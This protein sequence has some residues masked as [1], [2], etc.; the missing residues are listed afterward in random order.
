MPQSLKPTKPGHL[1]VVRRSLG[2]LGADKLR[3]TILTGA[4]EPGERLTEEGIA[5]KLGLSRSTIRAC[6]IRLVHEG[7][8]VQEPYLGYSVRSLSSRDAWELFTLRNSMESFAAKILSES[9]S[10]KKKKRLDSAYQN[11]LTA[12][13]NGSRSAAVQADFSLHETIAELTE[14]KAFQYH[15]QLI[16][17]QVKLYQNLVSKFLSLEDYVAT[18]Q[19]L[20]D[21]IRA[22]DS[23]EAQLLAA[24]HNTQDGKM[25][26]AWLEESEEK[27][28]RDKKGLAA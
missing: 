25:L 6:L 8:I 3:E 11:V 2:D 13:K 10:E 12:V 21:A 27:V 28:I 19:P 5:E 26:V 1:T 15:Y 9:M 20:I 7:L 18:H 4:F 14:H 23:M 16:A 22:G 17:G 24:Q